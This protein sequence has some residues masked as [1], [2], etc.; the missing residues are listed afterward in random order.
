MVEK[1]QE[2]EQQVEREKFEGKLTG[3]NESIEGFKDVLDDFEVERIEMRRD[4]IEGVDELDEIEIM[5]ESIEARCEKCDMS[6]FE[7]VKVIVEIIED[8]LTLEDK[9]KGYMDKNNMADVEK[10]EVENRMIWNGIMQDCYA[11]DMIRSQENDWYVESI[12]TYGGWPVVDKSQVVWTD[13][14]GYWFN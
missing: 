8:A 12:Q 9:L 7:K 4:C 14:S 2:Q 11:W 10:D 1:F 5:R 13:C 6:E 3:Q